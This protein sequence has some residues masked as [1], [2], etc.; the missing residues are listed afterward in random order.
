M[1]TL[2]SITTRSGEIINIIEESAATYHK[3]GT[4]LL[5]DRHGRRVEIIEI[6]ERWKSANIMREI[7][8]QWIADDQHYSWATLTDCLRQCHL[9]TLA[10]RIEQHFGL[11][12][13]PK[14]G[15]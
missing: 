10:Y 13:P 11:P 12:S 5:Q 6:D 15:I 8:K 2:E 9:K 4:I 7:Y 14:E 1:V 3:I